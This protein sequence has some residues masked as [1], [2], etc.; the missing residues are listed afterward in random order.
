MYK[1]Q[2]ELLKALNAAGIIYVMWKVAGR[3]IKL[4]CAVP[5]M[6]KHATCGCVCVFMCD[7]APVS[8]HQRGRAL[9]RTVPL[10]VTCKQRFKQT[11]FSVWLAQWHHACA[12][13]LKRFGGGDLAQLRQQAEGLRVLADGGEA[14]A[15]VGKFGHAVAQVG[16]GREP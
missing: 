14:T 16:D 1:Y 8:M 12:S 6:C 9:A 4:L 11:K 13:A 2:Y 15:E 7:L 3:R 5:R 10:C